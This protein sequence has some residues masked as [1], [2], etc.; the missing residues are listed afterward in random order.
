MNYEFGYCE[1]KWR[2]T[3]SGGSIIPHPDFA[4]ATKWIAKY[5]HRDGFIYPPTTRTVSNGKRVKNTQRPSHLFRLP[6]SHTVTLTGASG[7]DAAREKASFAIHLFGYYFGGWYQ[8]ADWWFDARVPLRSTHNIVVDDD[9]AEH[10]LSHAWDTW[11]R[12][13]EPERRRF[14]NILFMLNRAPA[15]E[16]DWEHF[17]LEYMVFDACYRMARELK[18]LPGKKDV[19]HSRRLSAMCDL[20]GIPQD[21][22]WIVR[23]VRL[24]NDLLHE[25][26]WDRGR[27]GSSVDMSTFYTP[28]HL[29][30]LNQ[31]IIPALLNYR[32][33]YVVTPW[34]QLGTF[35]FRRPV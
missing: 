31:R 34:W 35:S 27:P 15:Y 24:R 18:Y 4:E 23:I 17:V 20:F 6:R 26:L 32:T 14:A 29:R 22:S 9:V 19:P 2:L 7:K 8:F 11:L 21:S 16:W 33:S 1:H 25:T 13:P 28:L 5:S 10:F 3:F 12:W 30:R